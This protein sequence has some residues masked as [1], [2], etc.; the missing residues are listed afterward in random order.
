LL[1]CGLF[2]TL[3][4]AGLVTGDGSNLYSKDGL[5]NV[6]VMFLHGVAFLCI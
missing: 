6:L 5:F 1:Q 4:I 3:Q 2:L